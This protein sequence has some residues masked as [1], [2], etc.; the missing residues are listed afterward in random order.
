MNTILPNVKFAKSEQNERKNVMLCTDLLQNI[1]H[2]IDNYT[3]SCK[4]CLLICEAFKFHYRLEHQ[5]II[6]HTVQYKDSILH[7]VVAIAEYKVTTSKCVHNV[8]HL[9]ENGS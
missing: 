9:F 8:A 7:A 4:V 3:I 5:I 6:N 1:L 2:E